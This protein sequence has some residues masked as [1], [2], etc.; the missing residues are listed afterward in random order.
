MGRYAQGMRLLL[1]LAIVV[2]VAASPAQ[3]P[4]RPAPAAS[5]EIAQ[6][7]AAATKAFVGDP[8][9][10]G[11][12]VGVRVVDLATDTVLVDHDG[13][14]G[15]MTASNMKLVSSALA[16]T[17]LGPEFRF[18]TRI[19]TRAPLEDGVLRGDLTLVGSGDPTLGARQEEDPLAP[20]LAM[21]K[22]L[23]AA[24]VRTVAGRII[25]DDDV[26]RDEV[27]G[28]GWQWDYQ[29]AAY[30]AQISGL[31]FAENVIHVVVTGTE[32]GE[33]PR[34]STHPDVG[35]VLVQNRAVT[36]AADGG[37]TVDAERRRATNTIVLG[38]TIAAG[39]TERIRVSVENPTRYAAAALR[40][41]LVR[42][43]I[44]VQGQPVD[45][46]DSGPGAPPDGDSRVLA[47]HRSQPLGE[48]LFTLNKVSQNL[49]AEQMLR[50]GGRAAQG[51]AVGDLEVGAAG[52]AAM[53]R[54]FGVTTEGLGI[55]DGSGLTRRNLV[56]PRHLT[57]LLAGMWRHAHRK[58][59]L[60]TLP[61][62][63]VD[64]TLSSRFADGPAKGRVRAKTGYISRVVALSGY[65]PRQNQE[66]FVFSILV[67]NFT[68]PTADAKAA[69][70]RFVQ[71]L[72]RAAGWET[73]ARV[74]AEGG[75]VGR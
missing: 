6:R 29:S 73:A 8:A 40:T 22:D 2:W 11:G 21:A 71:E 53:L 59:F 35:Y 61:I 48:I 13:D 56:Q 63:G 37:A 43:G 51:A 18:L 28:Q 33:R 55:E 10:A 9:L 69:V 27:M 60:R 50:V 44:Q 38:G 52:A 25:G 32:P 24:G 62:A 12:R 41:A 5:P 57:G 30:A 54:G 20:F 47:M 1:P 70:D 36:G 7:L 14:K 66:P 45:I 72:A 16:L 3:T 49:Y 42:S 46:D 17:A 15:F 65:V 31:C 39:K 75:P 64:G 67:N 19:E 68:C 74:P 58:V 34:V 23:R 26:H 4:A